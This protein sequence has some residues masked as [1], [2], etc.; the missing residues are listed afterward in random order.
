[1]SARPA[2]YRG[3]RWAE[4]GSWSYELAH[5]DGTLRRLPGI[6]TRLAFRVTGPQRYCLGH[7]SFDGVRGETRPCPQ[8]APVT[9]GRQCDRCRIREGWSV[10]HAH[11]G[12]LEALPEQVRGYIA[13]PH[14]LYIAYFGRGIAKVGTAS[15]VRRHRRLYEQGALV[16]RFIADSPDGLHVRDLER[17]VSGETGLRQAVPAAT[18]TRVLTEPLA[19]WAALERELAEAADHA[20]TALPAGTAAAGA[21]WTGGA[22]FYA[23]LHAR[24]RYPTATDFAAP[25]GEYALDAVTAH[26]HTLACRAESGDGELVLVDDSRLIGRRIELDDTITATPEPAQAGL[27]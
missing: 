15:A 20:A 2:L 14:H 21:H 4:D 12:P 27:F 7:R 16:A 24:G 5:P 26:G 22:R 3:T 17:L 19:A 10:V 18:K 25:T 13:Q 6:G 8:A 1:M 23:T 11:R 9:A